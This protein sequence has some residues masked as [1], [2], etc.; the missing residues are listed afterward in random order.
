[1]RNISNA[2][3]VTLSQKTGTEPIC[4]IEVEW[5]PGSKKL[6]GDKAIQVEGVEGRIL[7]LA[8]IDDILSISRQTT[9]QSVSVTLDDTDGEMKNLFN[10]VDIHKR[11]ATVYQW[12]TGIPISDKFVLFSGIIASP[13]IWKEGDR[14]LTFTIISKTEDIEVGFSPEEGQFPNLPQN[15]VGQVWP[16][17]FGTVQKLPLVRVDEIPYKD[18]TGDLADATTIDD[19][20]IEDP[21]LDPHIKD[22]QAQADYA[23]QLAQLY[24]LGYLE[25]SFTARKLGELGDLDDID[26]GKGTYSGLAKQYLAEGNKYFLEAQKIRRSNDKIKVVQNR[27]KSFNKK[28]IAVT[29]GTLFPQ[30]V[31][32]KVQINGAQ[33]N[34]YFL[35]NTFHIAEALHPATDK[36]AEIPIEVPDSG[37]PLNNYT[38]DNFFWNPAGQRLALGVIAGE[39]PV[40]PAYI[41]Y[42]V[43]ATIQVI[44]RVVYAFRDIDG[45]RQ[46]SVLPPNLYVIE[47]PFFGTLPVT[48][49]IVPSPLSSLTDATGKNLGWS[50][51]LYVSC[52][53]PVGPNAVDIITWLIQTYTSHTIDATSFTSVRID[54]DP[55]PMHFALTSRPNVIALVQDIAYQARCIVW[56]QN[57]VF[58]IK[59]LS[60][61]DSSVATITEADIIEQ[62]LEVSYTETEDLTT[63]VKASWKAD[64][65]QR[66]S[67]LVILRYNIAFYG[68]HEQSKEYYCYNMQQLVEKAS[69]FWLIRDSN[70]YKK[71]TCKV[72]I[73]FLNI[74]TLDTVT[75]NFAHP[76]IANTAIDCIVESA[77]V[78]TADYTISLSLWVPVRAGE[79][80]EYLFAFPSG[81]SIQYY[82]PTET[83]VSI[84]RAGS[85]HDV[86]LTN[87][88]RLPVSGKTEVDKPFTG[89]SGNGGSVHVSRRPLTYGP[90]PTYF[91]DQNNVAPEI[92][93]RIDSTQLRGTAAAQPSGTSRYQ[94]PRSRV[95]NVPFN[96]SNF[97]TVFPCKISNGGPG[98]GP[99]E[100]KVYLQGIEN[101]PTTVREAMCL[102][103]DSEDTI[104]TDNWL[105]VNRVVFTTNTGSTVVKWYLQPPVWQ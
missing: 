101:D 98:K 59:F 38:R 89:D 32:Q 95:T 66:Q 6:Y 76:Y 94:L 64:Y 35:G 88:V 26:K 61:K 90:D 56:L 27:Q 8:Q 57:N 53:S 12:F 4:L 85:G 87:N 13:I 62:T 93:Q 28:E 77:V 86:P 11:P 1:M 24:F 96:P 2:S 100:I 46:L 97:T 16:L 10:N 105:F 17:V 36:Y 78:D 82:W 102:Q 81:L 83:D 19:H 25:A 40:T 73:K 45:Q 104:E 42:I 54:V 31:D 14:T 9:S 41:R 63:K 49:L 48:M 18:G 33:Y 67:N 75:L 60:K 5:T 44:V 70:T 30:G 84:G 69:V 7:Q 15:M 23:G 79:M 74:E 72:P 21:A 29:N 20:G 68:L 55:Y 103:L 92:V 51:D 3:L 37:E 80:T 47:Q 39:T 65:Y 71:V 50:D 34:G 52:M 43:A 99:Y 91:S 58:H 22:Q